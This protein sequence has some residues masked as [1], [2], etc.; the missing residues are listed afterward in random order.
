VAARYAAKFRRIPL[1]TVN[2]QFGGW[3]RAQKAF[4]ADGGVFDRIYKPG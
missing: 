2:A 3:R 1:V 4:F